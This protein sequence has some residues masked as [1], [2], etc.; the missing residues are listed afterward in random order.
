MTTQLNDVLRACIDPLRPYLGQL[1]VAGGWVPYL[2]TRLY[3]GSVANA[4]LLTTDFD[5]AVVRR[6]LIEGKVTLDESI[7]SSG[8]AY[9]FAS[10]DNPPVVRYVKSLE[11]GS[12]A[13]IEFITD[14][15]G[16]AGRVEVI[17]SVNAQALQDVDLL[18]DRPWV[19]PL[20]K[21]GELGEGELRL[22]RPSRFV[23]HKVLVAPRRGRW[24]KTA[25]DLY[26]AFC[27]FD[28]FPLWRS[29]MLEEVGAFAEEDPKRASRAASYLSEM[30]ESIDAEGAALLASQRPQTAYGVMD[31]DQFRLYALTRMCQLLTALQRS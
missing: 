31:E 24:E 28:C 21:I 2:Y 5:V 13:E 19:R 27:T 1:V 9:D 6:G 10:L 3:E 29:Q 20:A 17:G 8:F 26:Y 30:F 15:A 4:P 16:A 14:A 11:N 12:Q 18:L 25:K 23:V 22:P 7:L